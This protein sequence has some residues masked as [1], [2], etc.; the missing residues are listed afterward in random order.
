MQ[1]LCSSESLPLSSI[2]LT[3]FSLS[4]QCLVYKNDYGNMNSDSLKEMG[5]ADVEWPLEFVH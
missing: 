1:K 4:S 3:A 2:T 5:E